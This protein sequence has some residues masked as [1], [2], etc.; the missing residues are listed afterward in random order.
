MKLSIVTDEVSADLETA[1]ELAKTWNLEGVELRGI[2]EQRY[3]NV[4]A[5]W[6]QRVPQLTEEYGL[7]VVAISSGLFKIPYPGQPPAGTRLLR[8]EDA[9][10][11]ERY[12][13]AEALVRQHLDVLLP[14]TIQAAKQ[15]GAKIIVCFS[16]DRG[17]HIPATDPV[18]EA[19]IDALKDA[20]KIVEA[21]GLSLAIEV[22]HVCWG[23]IG[24]R[25]VQIVERVGSPSLGINWDPA[26]AFRAGSDRPFPDGYQAVREH[27]R[28]VH[29]K[30]ADI[31]DYET[32]QRGFVFNGKVNW[33]G[34]I[35]A[36]LNDGYQG[37]MS[38][39]THVK[40][41]VEMARRSL[42]RVRKWMEDV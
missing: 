5:F 16:F 4:S 17:E 25:T 8:W 11:F 40:P 41:K 18:P 22:E 14:D 34:Q 39:E 29:Y 33:K 28:H 36:L 2:G 20:A 9:M 35:A 42:D 13:N 26:N 6:K 27:I 12:Q 24:S 21:A 38:I 32:G 7:P 23:D 30:D 10:V 1:L 37:Y 19:V 15:L 3:P 31:I